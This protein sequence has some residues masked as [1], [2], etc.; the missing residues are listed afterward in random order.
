VKEIQRL[1][2][3]GVDIVFDPICGT[4]LWHSRKS[5]RPGGRVAGYGLISSIRGDWPLVVQVVVNAF[6]E[7]LCSGCISPAVGSSRPETDRSLQHPDT[8]TAE[9]RDCFDRI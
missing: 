9:N 8:Q 2:G 6:A 4:H 3:D 7:P 1:T 5:L